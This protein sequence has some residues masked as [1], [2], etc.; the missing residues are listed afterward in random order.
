MRKVKMKR[1]FNTTPKPSA[2]LTKIVPEV[3]THVEPNRKSMATIKPAS[4]RMEMK[5][6]FDKV[7]MLQF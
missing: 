5:A 4:K 3:E 6:V 2:G 1:N 7:A